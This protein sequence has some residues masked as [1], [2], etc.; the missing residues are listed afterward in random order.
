VL[1][2][3]APSATRRV[4]HAS[5]GEGDHQMQ[6]HAE[7]RRGGP[8]RECSWSEETAR[9]PLKDA[10]GRCAG[11]PIPDDECRQDVEDTDEDTGSNDGVP[12]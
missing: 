10:D 1:H 4:V 12:V 3:N 6:Q 5:D 9:S 11:E 7:N 2:Q 8:A